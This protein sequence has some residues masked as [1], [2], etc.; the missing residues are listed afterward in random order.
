MVKI[1]KRS[2]SELNNSYNV[3]R[4]YHKTV[5]YIIELFLYIKLLL[6]S[7]SKLREIYTYRSLLCATGIVEQ[8]W[9]PGFLLC[10][11]TIKSP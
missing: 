11:L 10:G 3:N 6:L 1:H 8:W 7:Y 2:D 4:F 9:R 5:K